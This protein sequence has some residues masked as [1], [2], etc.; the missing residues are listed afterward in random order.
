MLAPGVMTK[1]PSPCTFCSA[2][3]AIFEEE[4]RC[5]TCQGKK[6][7]ENTKLF[8]VKIDPGVPN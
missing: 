1:T 2:Q 8:K 6:V 5:K 7:V 4:K 3:G